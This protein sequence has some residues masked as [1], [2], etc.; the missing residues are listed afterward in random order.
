MRLIHHINHRLE[1]R[2]SSQT[3]GRTARTPWCRTALHVAGGWCTQG[4]IGRPVGR[5]VYLPWYREACRE[6]YPPWYTHHV[7]PGIPTLVI[8]I[9]YTL[10][11]YTCCTPWVYTP[12]VHPGY[13]LRYYGHE[14]Q[15]GACSPCSERDEAQS[16]ACSPCSESSNEAQSGA[17]FPCYSVGN[18]AQSGARSSC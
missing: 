1:P 15:R 13:T 2:A 11:I 4:G 6:G 17:L 12:V 14:A 10:G 7:H 3:H 5:G 16:G 18:E 9:M 8:P